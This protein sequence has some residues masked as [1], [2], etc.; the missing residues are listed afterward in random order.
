MRSFP[1]AAGLGLSELPA[2]Q[3]GIRVGHSS[4]EAPG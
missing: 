1:F 4:L 2:S 3:M